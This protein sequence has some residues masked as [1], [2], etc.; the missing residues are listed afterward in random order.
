MERWYED[1]DSESMGGNLRFGHPI[2][3]YSRINF[4]YEYENTDISNVDPDASLEIQE[5]EGE[6]TIGALTGGIS[7]STLDNRFTP[8][9]GSLLSFTSKLAGIGGDADFFT[10][11]A[12]AAKYFPMPWDSAFMIRGTIGYSDGLGGD[13]VPIFEKFFL[14]GLD[15]I[16][17]FEERTVGPRE[18]RRSVDPFITD[19]DE[20]DVVGGEKQLFFNVEYIFPILK[21]AGIRGVVFFDTGN[22]Y[23]SSEDYFSDMRKSAGFGVRWQSPFGPLRL[24]M[25]FNL[26]RESKYDESSSEF[27]F[28]M[29]QMF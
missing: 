8:R 9:R 13:D 19:P 26:D 23:R 7:R 12:S 1:F 6:T 29:G 21:E 16:R 24:E 14:G 11:I 27:H 5:S 22:A 20:Y 17:G 28:T 3:E 10:L 2:G 4:G 18:L 25:G 15:S